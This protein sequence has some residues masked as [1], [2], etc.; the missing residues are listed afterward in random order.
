MIASEAP[1]PTQNLNGTHAALPPVLDQAV[2][3]ELAAWQADGRLARLWARDA[4]LWTGGDEARWLGWLGR[5]AIGGRYSV[6]SPFGLVPAAAAGIDLRTACSTHT[7]AMVRSCGPDV[8]P[9]ENPG[10]QLGPRDGP[11]R[12]RR[13]RQGDDLSSK[14]I[15]DFGAWAE[16]LIAESTGKD[17]KGLIP[18]DGE[19]WATSAGSTATTASSS[20]SAPKAKT[21]RA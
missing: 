4:S 2:A 3:R 13:P 12:P 15:A 5:S 10:V 7:L 20:T 6:L 11:R 19:R 9:H 17:G 16:Q 1:R 14:K 18:I 8:P 21:T